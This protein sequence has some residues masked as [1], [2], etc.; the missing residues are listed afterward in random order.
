MQPDNFVTVYCVETYWRASPRRL[1]RGQFRQYGDRAEALTAGRR[2]ARARA[3]VL[4]FSVAGEP[5][6]DIWQ[7][8]QTLARFGDAPAEAPGVV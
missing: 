6:A 1:V 7:R 3:G 2:M 4:V 8:P 5:V